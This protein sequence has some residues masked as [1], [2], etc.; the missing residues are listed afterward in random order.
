M[1]LL[2]WSI[3]NTY[4]EPPALAQTT[5]QN[6]AECKRLLRAHGF[7]SRAQF[8]CDFREYSSE[9]LEAARSCAQRFS[10]T[11]MQELIRGG[12]V[13]FDENEKEKGHKSLC[14][15]ILIKFPNIV[16]N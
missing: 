7:L 16:R 3:G 9:M 4:L 13:L 12:M 1:V 2:L 15:E 5:I 6:D 8:Q 14:E 10:E 11:A